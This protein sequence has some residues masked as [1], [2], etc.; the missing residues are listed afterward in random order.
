MNA[1]FL[2]VAG[3]GSQILILVVWVISQWR[4]RSVV[5]AMNLEK[6]GEVPQVAASLQTVTAQMGREL[7]VWL[8]AVGL[9]LLGWMLFIYAITRLKY[10]RLWAFWFACIYGACLIC[11]VPLGTPFGLFLVI[12]A[13]IHRQEFISSAAPRSISVS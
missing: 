11:V 12:F 3:A 10:R 2:A 9:A 6:A 1:H 7:D 13:W 4:L 8:G 5:S